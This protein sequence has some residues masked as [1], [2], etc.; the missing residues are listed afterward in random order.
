MM[1][2]TLGV[3]MQGTMGAVMQRI[4]GLSFEAPAI[5]YENSLH[6]E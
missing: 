4:L 6:K 2:G 3:M 5:W 1:Q